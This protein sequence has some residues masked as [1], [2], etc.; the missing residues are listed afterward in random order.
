MNKEKEI[1][2]MARISA[3]LNICE[4]KCFECPNISCEVKARVQRLQNAGY[5]N[6]KQAIK[7]FAEKL[8]EIA[9]DISKDVG[10]EYSVLRTQT[11]LEQIDNL[12]TELYGGNE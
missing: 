5:G 4:F 8:K 6:V 3:T 12:I 7:E 9:I 1:E 2:E 10:I 11:L